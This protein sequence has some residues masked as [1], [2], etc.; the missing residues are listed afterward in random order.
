[1]QTRTVWKEEML[2]TGE[3]E[4]NQVQMDA[5]SPIGSGKGV[6]YPSFIL[7]DEATNATLAAGMICS[8]Q[9][10]S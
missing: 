2:F 8:N 6:V 7:I 1:M 5:K 4:G 10:E 9:F 3:S